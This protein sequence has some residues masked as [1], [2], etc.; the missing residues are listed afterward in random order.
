[1]ATKDKGGKVRIAAMAPSVKRDS[2][3][4]KLHTRAVKEAKKAK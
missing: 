1:M 2:K 4:E 3:A